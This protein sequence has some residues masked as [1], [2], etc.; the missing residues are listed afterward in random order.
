V[1]TR[2]RESL[3][4]VSDHWIDTGLLPAAQSETADDPDPLQRALEA[5]RN[6][7]AGPQRRQRAPRRINPRGTR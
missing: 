4:M 3:Q 6:R 2:Y 5:R 1:A 7:N